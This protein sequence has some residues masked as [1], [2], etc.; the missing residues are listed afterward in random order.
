M[1]TSEGLMSDT[2]IITIWDMSRYVV[3][4]LSLL[5]I[6]HWDFFFEC[7]IQIFSIIEITNVL[8]YENQ[9]LF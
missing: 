2:P 8:M 4:D 6:N 1:I 7:T 3:I 5:I 9:V